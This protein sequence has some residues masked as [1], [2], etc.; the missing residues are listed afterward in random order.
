M[1]DGIAQP[2]G[3]PPESY[4]QIVDAARQAHLGIDK[5]LANV[6][7]GA[8]RLYVPADCTNESTLAR[9][10][11][12]RVELAD[13]L[14]HLPSGT[15]TLSDAAR[16]LAVNVRT[17][18]ELC[19]GGYINSE[20]VTSRLLNRTIRVVSGESLNRFSANHIALRTIAGSKPENFQALTHQL[21]TAGM[22]PIEISTK[23]YRIYRREDLITY[24]KSEAGAYL[25]KVLEYAEAKLSR[26]KCKNPEAPAP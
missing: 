21:K 15:V 16:K 22:R 9:Y 13:A 18:R 25:Q 2:S 10:L 1:L 8:L 12:D 20:V 14:G 19:L 6:T 7:R 11:I 3:G 24:A 4:V 23:S 17:A 5:I 26:D